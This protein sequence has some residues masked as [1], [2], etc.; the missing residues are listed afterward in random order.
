MGSLSKRLSTY[1]VKDHV[2]RQGSMCLRAR[3]SRVPP[4]HPRRSKEETM[5]IGPLV[6]AALS[7]I[8]LFGCG[9]GG[10]G[11]GGTQ[12]VATTPVK[13][14]IH[15]P[16]RVRALEAPTSALSAVVI[17]SHANPDGTDFT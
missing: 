4:A 8:L 16:A 10:G 15:W 1:V 9:G 14:N 2:C 6:I 5:R 7:C 3:P 12:N 17:L 11:G 13:V